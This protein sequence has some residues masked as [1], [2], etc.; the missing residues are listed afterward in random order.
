MVAAAARVPEA[1]PEELRRPNHSARSPTPTAWRSGGV[2]AMSSSVGT[3]TAAVPA[4]ATGTAPRNTAAG[5]SFRASAAE[6]RQE[7]APW[8]SSLLLTSRPKRKDR[9]RRTPQTR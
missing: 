3:A 2:E 9:H 8:R 5:G 4:G 1:P 7:S 6:L